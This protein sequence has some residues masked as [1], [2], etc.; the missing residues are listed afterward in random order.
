MT[1][2]SFIFR[3]LEHVFCLGCVFFA[4]VYEKAQN[5]CMLTLVCVCVC[6]RVH[7]PMHI[8]ACIHCMS[9]M[10]VDMGFCV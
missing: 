1:W 6:V 9:F 10:H 2:L 3:G 4:Q 8:C 5:V 7:A